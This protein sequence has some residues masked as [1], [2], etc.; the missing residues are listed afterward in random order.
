MKKA[1]TLVLALLLLI[2][3]VPFAAAKDA[4][5][6]A[7]LWD[8]GTNT[9]L[10]VLV[11]KAFARAS[12]APELVLTLEKQ[13]PITVAATAKTVDFLEGGTTAPRVLLRASIPLGS[14][15]EIDACTVPEGTCFDKNGAANPAAQISTFAH[16]NRAHEIRARDHL[17][18]GW[19]ADI[20]TRDT[21]AVGDTAVVWYE[22]L[23]D[24]ELYVNGTLA[25]KLEAGDSQTI[26]FP[27][28]KTGTLTLS[29]R[30]GKTELRTRSF[31]VISSRAMYLQNLKESRKYFDF[32]I[33][34]EG[35]S[36]LPT[37]NLFA[38]P[39]LLAMAFGAFFETLLSFPR[40]VK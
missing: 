30:R 25:C 1:I 21:L 29:I 12:D 4:D 5:W 6:R 20:E 38:Y 11:P 2:S 9:H 22:D 18:D 24:A 40:I 17:G 23:D 32:S 27:L 16:W 10:C 8:D 26:E 33:Y 39:I 37:G 7:W 31:T 28:E 3:A 15:D 35:G 34:G 13:A 19:Y 14:T 36:G